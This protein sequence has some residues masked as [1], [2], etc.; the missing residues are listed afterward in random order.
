MLQ[1]LISY[2][3]EMS[4]IECIGGPSGNLVR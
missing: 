1:S 4:T 2:F 3:Q